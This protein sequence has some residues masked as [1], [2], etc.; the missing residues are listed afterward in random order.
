[1]YAYADESG[2]TG[3]NIFD[4]QQPMFLT[5]AL[6]TKTNFDILH[7]ANIRSI[8]NFL[9]EPELHANELGPDRVE[10]YAGRL[11][12]IIKK[13]DAGFFISRVE[14]RYLATT[15]L[16]DTLFDSYENKAVPWH[17][18]NLRPLRLM[19]VFKI[20]TI[21]EEDTAKKFWAALMEPKRDRAYALLLESLEDIS[22]NVQ[23]LPDE[24]SRSLINEAIAWAMKNP[25]EIYLHTN[26]KAA[27]ME[28]LPNIAMFPNL[29]E[30]IEKHSQLWKRPVREIIH[31]RQSQFEK[32]LKAW[33][34]LTSNAAP[35]VITWTM[36]EKY[37]VR[38]VPGSV[39][40]IS[41]AEESAGIQVIDTILWLF[42]RVLEDKPLGVD[43][44][45]L[46]IH[47]FRRAHQHD[48]SF[49]SVGRWLDTYFSE[50]YAKPFGPEDEERGREFLRI[51]EERRQREL[52]E[53]A[54]NKLKAA[55]GNQLG[56]KE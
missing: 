53:Y 56:V 20:A 14:K 37:S 5:A 34:E 38:R 27:R 52:A 12:R 22:R 4:P 47:I 50:L 9:G 43:S 2:N 1:M 35:G 40:R 13:T 48:M 6:I 23:Q 18:Y 45:K 41:S 29:L 10:Q 15:K 33:H 54:E 26:S 36:G 32:T 25:E 19:M 16:V 21:L 55:S 39:F 7:K 11:L 8:A 17:I 31:D 46:M 3:A 30:G 44:E 28:H 24:R 49:E 42:K 51:A